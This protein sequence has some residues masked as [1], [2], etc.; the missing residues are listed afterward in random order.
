MTHV[1]FWEGIARD[2]TGRGMLGGRF[3]IR[4]ILQPMVA[5]ILGVRLGIRDAKE[6]KPAFFMSF[7]TGGRGRWAILRQGLRDAIVPLCV[8]FVLDG[9]LQEIIL[10]RVRP[11]AAVVVGLLLV[12]LPFVLMRGISNRIWSHRHHAPVPHT[13]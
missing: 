13:P 11:A 6:G 3:Q 2:L 4:L 9:I 10:H 1:G 12:F 7:V 5:M 8:A